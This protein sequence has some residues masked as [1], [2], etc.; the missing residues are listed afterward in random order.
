LALAAVLELG[1]IANACQAPRLSH[2]ATI[3][4][5]CSIGRRSIAAVINDFVSRP[6]QRPP[7]PGRRPEKMTIARSLVSPATELAR[8][9]WTLKNNFVWK[10]LR[11]A[12]AAPNESG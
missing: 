11:I 2:G 7:P 12:A 4:W 8:N 5:R 1:A 9:A 6:S 3:L 10:L